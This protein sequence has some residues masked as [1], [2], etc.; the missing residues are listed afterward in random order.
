MCAVSFYNKFIKDEKTYY[1]SEPLNFPFTYLHFIE[2]QN[3][4]S[5]ILCKYFLY[6][7]EIFYA[8]TVLA[9]KIRKIGKMHWLF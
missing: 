8:E 1:I 4:Y 6:F 3:A 2:K 9:L 5:E 7:N